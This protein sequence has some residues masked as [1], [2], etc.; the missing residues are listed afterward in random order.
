MV[1]LRHGS[2]TASGL[3]CAGRAA[4]AFAYRGYAGFVVKAWRL[5]HLGNGPAIRALNSTGFRGK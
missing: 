3:R 2:D 4:I 1:T 5:N